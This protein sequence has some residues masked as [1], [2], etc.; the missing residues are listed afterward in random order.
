MS[1]RVFKSLLLIRLTAWSSA[2]QATHIVGGE[3]YYR[4][5]GNNQYEIQ[6]TVYRDCFYGVPPFD[7]PAY[8]GVWD[9]N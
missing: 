7:E 4:Y 3:L 9:V 1:I 8:V 6:L 5:L 2:G